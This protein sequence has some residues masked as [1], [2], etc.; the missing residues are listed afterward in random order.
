MRKWPFIII[1]LLICAC[2]SKQVPE[3]KDTSAS[4]LENYKY[5]F[6]TDKESS[7]EP[8]FLKAK[9][10]IARSND[11]DLLG[12]AYLT[13]FAMHVSILEDFDDTDFLQINKL[14]PNAKNFAY[15]NF[16]KG[17][18]QTADFSLLPSQYGKLLKPAQDKDLAA[19]L[20]EISL[21]DDPVSRL[22]ACGV[23]IKHLPFDDNF[24]MLAI[25]TSAENGW[26]RPLFAYLNKLKQYYLDH[27][28]TAKAASIKE[29]LELLKK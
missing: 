19:A 17:N 8:H 16:I 5:S 22:V 14:Q 11:L 24:L 25:N 23:W 3:W 10:A 13:N 7:A 21:M 18:F 29:R 28:E 20:K 12:T 27:N 9:K 6:L 26:S 15:Y 4:Q 1:L 2:G